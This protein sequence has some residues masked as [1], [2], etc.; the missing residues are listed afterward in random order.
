MSVGL[1][2]LAPSATPGQ[3]W[4]RDDVTFGTI[5]SRARELAEKDYVPPDTGSLPDWLTKLGYDQ[6]RAI[7]FK[8]EHELWAGEDLPFR[9]V[10]F[11]PGYLY[12]EPVQLNEFTPTHVQRIRQ[13]ESFFDYG[14]LVGERGD[15]PVEAGFSGFRLHSPLVSGEGFGEVVAFQGASYWRALGKGQRY[16]ISARGIAVNTAMDDVEEEFPG[17]R[18]FWLGKPATDDTALTVFALLDGPS[19]T[20]AYS[21]R[22][23]PGE[24]TTVDVACVLFAR[25]EVRRFG[26]APMSSMFWFGENS[27]RRFD[28]FR[29]EVHDSDGLSIRTGDGRRIWRPL[30]NDTGRLETSVFRM[31]RCEGFGL[32]QRDRAHYHYEDEEAAYRLRPSLWI[33]P[34]SDWGP[35]SVTLIEI[36]THHETTD[37]IVAMWEPETPPRP[38]ERVEFRYRQHWTM[39]PDP[40]GGEGLVVATRTG[41]HDWLPEQRGMIVEFAGG[42]LDEDQER[43]PEAVVESVGSSSDRIRIDGVTVQRQPGRRWR[44]S[45]QIHPAEEGGKLA[46]VGAVEL[47]CHL[48]RGDTP[49]T[50]TWAYR[51]VP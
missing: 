29:P 51:I 46:D 26:I 41:V 11:H 32:L 3:D 47:L 21:F 22:I 28:D 39:R 27:R 5:E 44:V 36:P 16:G 25:T 35:G 15:L 50:E 9:A 45:F 24:D 23:E 2:A 6:Y 12:R 42:R 4:Q 8:P 19:F 34:A 18:E 48:K 38:G 43:K 14:D 13:S 1:L 30:A 17:F 37:N 40:A 33:E 31:E 7:G 49:V 20:G 10:F